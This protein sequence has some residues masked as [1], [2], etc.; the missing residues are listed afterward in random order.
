VEA[1]EHITEEVEAEVSSK[2]AGVKERT[3]DEK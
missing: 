1:A 3:T 2:T